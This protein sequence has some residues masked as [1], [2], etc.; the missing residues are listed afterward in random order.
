HHAGDVDL[1]ATDMAVQVDPA[2]HDDLAGKVQGLVC[3][4]TVGGCCHDAAVL[5]P[6]VAN[7]SIDAVDRVVGP[8]VRQLQQHGMES[9][10]TV[11]QGDA[12][13]SLAMR[14]QRMKA[15]AAHL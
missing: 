5:K 11:P 3:G 15:R 6:E 14:A 13:A 7:F 2:G 9:P 10:V 1:A 12:G 8:A 4:P